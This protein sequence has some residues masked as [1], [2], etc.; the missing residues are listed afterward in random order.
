MH[1]L[2]EEIS[3]LE[4]GEQGEQGRKELHSD[5]LSIQ[6]PSAPLPLCPSAPLP[7]CP[8]AP[9]PLESP[10]Y[11]SQGVLARTKGHSMPGCGTI[12]LQSLS[13][14]L[15]SITLVASQVIHRILRGEAND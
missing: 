15:G 12:L 2:V 11:S 14:P 8:S 5:Y 13:M 7:L 9:L 4:Q 1:Q 10:L 3:F 6:S